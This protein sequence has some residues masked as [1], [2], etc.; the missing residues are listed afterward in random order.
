MQAEKTN[1]DLPRLPHPPRSHPPPARK[2]SLGQA[3]L[4]CPACPCP[5]RCLLGQDHPAL[6]PPSLT[7]GCTQQAPEESKEA[8][9]WRKRS[10]MSS[11]RDCGPVSFPIPSY[12]LPV[13]GEG[14]SALAG[15]SGSDVLLLTLRD[16]P[17]KGDFTMQILVRTQQN[18]HKETKGERIHLRAHLQSP[19][20]EEQRGCASVCWS[21]SRGFIYSTFN[22]EAIPIK[23]ELLLSFSL[24]P[25]DTCSDRQKQKWGGISELKKV[26]HTTVTQILFLCVIPI[27]C[28]PPKL[29]HVC[30]NN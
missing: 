23:Q 3:A 2:P 21:P 10:K 8:P 9:G 22:S 1:P 18:N 5:A 25:N 30:W 14:C 16:K 27:P 29:L 15:T 13:S 4:P 11:K 6:L 24:L 19:V 7:L 12:F 26:N 20:K 28:H 17:A